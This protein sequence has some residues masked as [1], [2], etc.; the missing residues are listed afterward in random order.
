MP[1]ERN[2]G[3]AAADVFALVLSSAALYKRPRPLSVRMTLLFL[4]DEN[5]NEDDDEFRVRAHHV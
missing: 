1:H 4:V 3:L 5:E 2:R